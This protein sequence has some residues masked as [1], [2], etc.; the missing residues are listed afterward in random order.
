MV[1]RKRPP[2][3]PYPAPRVPASYTRLAEM[4]AG[5]ATLLSNTRGR[6]KRRARRADG[7]KEIGARRC[8]VSVGGKG[9]KMQSEANNGTCGLFLPRILRRSIY[10]FD[11]YYKQYCIRAGPGGGISHHAHAR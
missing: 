5:Q 11:I 7:E 8:E 3:P 9:W 10:T 4:L 1:Y 2:P 6:E